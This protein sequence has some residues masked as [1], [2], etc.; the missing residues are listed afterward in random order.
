[1]KTRKLPIVS[2]LL[3][4]SLLVQP[5][6]AGALRLYDYVT[7]NKDGRDVATA[8]QDNNDCHSWY[9]VPGSI[10]LSRNFMHFTDLFSFKADRSSYLSMLSKITVMGK[11]YFDS[12]KDMLD[13]KKQIF[14]TLQNKSECA[15]KIGTAEAPDIALNSALVSIVGMSQSYAKTVKIKNQ[16]L[17]T[18][19]NTLDTENWAMLA[20]T[21][22]VP[23]DSVFSPNSPL[24][25]TLVQDASNFQTAKFLKTLIT[26]TQQESKQLGTIGYEL[27]GAIAKIHSKMSVTGTL[28]AEFDSHLETMECSVSNGDQSLTQDGMIAGLTA[29][30]F[31]PG[32]V[33]YSEHRTTCT[34]ALITELRNGKYGLN[35]A[36]DHSGSVFDINGKRIMHEF[37]NDKDE[38]HTVPLQ[39][40]VE[41]RLLFLFLKAN[42]EAQFTSISKEVF[43]VR[44]GKKGSTQV[45][46]DLDTSYIMNLAGKIDLQVPAYAYQMNASN[47]D[48]EYLKEEPFMCMSS[49]ATY[50]EQSKKFPQYVGRY[51]TPVKMEC[52]DGVK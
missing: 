39:S 51:P 1:M 38:C 32:G 41:M 30:G 6:Q 52:L 46:F 16:P 42:F 40:F 34:Q 22:A 20:P 25:Y 24:S 44:R 27:T 18:T 37:C 4:A 21:F 29:T 11:P 13:L 48:F 49:R 7:L 28:S 12:R 9:Y 19:T 31:S 23:K 17:P 15:G 2:A 14:A 26:D 33:G 8:F 45:E 10:E 3:T 5:A 35:F 50:T 43:E 47:L 36:F